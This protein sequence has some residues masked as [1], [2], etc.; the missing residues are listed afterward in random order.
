MQSGHS[1]HAICP[2]IDLNEMQFVYFE[3]ELHQG[4]L[5]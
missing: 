2:D 5:V 4:L 3:F 1:L